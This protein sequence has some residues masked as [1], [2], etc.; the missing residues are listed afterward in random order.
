MTTETHRRLLLDLR[1]MQQDPPFGTSAAPVGDDILKWEAV[2]FGPADTEWEGIF[3]LTLE[4]PNNY[5]TRPPLVKFKSR[6]FHPNVFTDGSICLD[7]LQNE[8]SP[9]YDVCA[10]L[11]SI[12]EVLRRFFT[13]LR[14]H[15]DFYHTLLTREQMQEFNLDESVNSRGFEPGKMQQL[16]TT[17][18]KEQLRLYRKAKQPYL[19]ESSESK[20]QGKQFFLAREHI[21]SGGLHARSA[22]VYALVPHNGAITPN[23]AWSQSLDDITIELLAPDGMEFKGNTTRVSISTSGLV[24]GIG[25]FELVNGTLCRE[26]NT[27]DSYWT[28]ED[29]CRLVIVLEKT[30]K[31][32]WDCVIKGDACIDVQEIENVVSLS[33]FNESQQREIL[34]LVKHHNSK[35]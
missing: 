29:G 1:K 31:T 16:V 30:Q 26:I 10:I 27:S 35:L 4:F 7:I 8:W 24:V 6:V 15:T 2:I 17:I 25:D 13:V 18:I 20:S 11:T 23:Y 33:N 5:P 19:L 22:P 9:V 28:I 3:T 21:S 14:T 32:W 12:Q 34:E